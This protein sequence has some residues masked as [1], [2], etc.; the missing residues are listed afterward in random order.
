MYTPHS[1]FHRAF[2]KIPKKVQKRKLQK[3]FKNET[4][5]NKKSPLVVIRKSKKNLKSENSKNNLPYSIS[6]LHLHLD[7]HLADRQ[8]L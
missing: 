4:S 8:V 5:K 1:S 7:A 6:S 2:A 3:Q